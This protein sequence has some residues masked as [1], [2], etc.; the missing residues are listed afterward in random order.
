METTTRT[1]ERRIGSYYETRTATTHTHKPFLGFIG[2]RGSVTTVTP[3][4]PARYNY[5]W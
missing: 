4:A 2:H 3:W 1:Q 5:F